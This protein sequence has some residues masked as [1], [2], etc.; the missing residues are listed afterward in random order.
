MSFDREKLAYIADVCT[1]IGVSMAT[2]FS[3]SIIKRVTG[4][5]FS[6][7]DLA[8]GTLFAFIVIFVSYWLLVLLVA[9]VRS[10]RNKKFTYGAFLAFVFLVLL[11]ISIGVMPYFK[12]CWANIFSNEYMLPN[13]PNSVFK[14]ISKLTV[15]E[16]GVI[17]GAVELSD[18]SQHVCVD[19]YVVLVYVK[20]DEESYRRK[21]QYSRTYFE[22]NSDLTFSTSSMRGPN[23]EK[24]TEAIVVVVRALDVSMRDRS[25]RYVNSGYAAA[26]TNIGGVSRI[27]EFARQ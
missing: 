23:R 11:N 21:D 27:V 26:L 18:P 4:E 17:S 13:R 10:L 14:Q 3:S 7:F 16:S 8:N 15:D 19:E 12:D 25:P 5:S 20:Y 22:I 9:S 6:F 1:I 24:P 2:F